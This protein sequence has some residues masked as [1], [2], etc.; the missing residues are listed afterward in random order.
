[1]LAQTLIEIITAQTVEAV[2]ALGLDALRPWFQPAAACL[3]LWDD[4]L[5]R[6]IVG[7]T[8]VAE[9]CT[10]GAADFRREALQR[11]QNA[12]AEDWSMARALEPQVFYQP[13]NE[14]RPK[15]GAMCHVGALLALGGA[16]HMP[17]EQYTHL[18]RVIT[19][20]LYTV[21][22]LE[23]AE[24]EHDQLHAERARLEQL[25][26]AV[27]QQR[28]T[29]DH[30]LAVERQF[31][32]SL[33]AKVEERTAALKAAQ[34]RLIQ[35]EKLAVIGQLASSLAHELNNPMQAIQSGLGLMQIELDMGNVNVV[36]DDLRIIQEELERMR[37]IFRQMLDFYRPASYDHVPLDLN[38]IG[39]GVRVLM[40]KRLQESH[41]TLTLDLT[42]R[43]PLTCGDNNQIKQVLI[44]LILNAA[45]AMP[46]TGG[47]ITLH[48]TFDAEHAYLIV[49]D[50][51]PG[52]APEQRAQLFEPLF[53]TKPR[54]LG[55][56]L[57]ISRE[58]IQRHAGRIT[59]ESEVGAGATFTICLP[60]QDDC[61]H[62]HEEAV[63]R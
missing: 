17:D 1:M 58:I 36:R 31:S 41:I 52:I 30:L 38:A 3:L 8:W 2:T 47:A 6:Y 39:E 24:R 59:V 11:A 53:T 19:R 46:P 62:E 9:D 18:L 54:G 5:Q 4:D 33:E 40:R 55:L 61:N 29:I 35:S 12:Y 20:T 42:P 56:G 15:N 23:Q 48:T 43:L 10:Y 21:A 51:G 50:D 27:E 7:A 25:L 34:Q 49:R 14:P 60:I 22:R 13:L 57:A 26:H 63:S 16:A 28:G 37:S 45:E 32:A 44:N